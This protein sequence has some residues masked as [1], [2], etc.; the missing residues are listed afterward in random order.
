MSDVA[1][2]LTGMSLAVGF[3]ILIVAFCLFMVPTEDDDGFDDPHST[4]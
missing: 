2:A 4:G 1:M 3:S